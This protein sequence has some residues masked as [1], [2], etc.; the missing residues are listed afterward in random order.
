M[1]ENIIFYIKKI[2]K[3]IELVDNFFLLKNIFLVIE[4][5]LKEKPKN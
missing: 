4:L 1:D 2:Q 3:E 5:E